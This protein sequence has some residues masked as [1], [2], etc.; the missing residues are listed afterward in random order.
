MKTRSS[1]GTSASARFSQNWWNAY[2][3]ISSRL[4]QI[5]PPSVLP[6]LVPSGFVIS[7]VA[8]A[9]TDSPVTRLIRSTPETRFPH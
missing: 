2:G 9:C 5:A 8:R 3:L 4:S 7:G 1:P 6:Y